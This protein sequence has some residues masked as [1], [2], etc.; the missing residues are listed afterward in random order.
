MPTSSSRK[1]AEEVSTTMKTIPNFWEILRQISVLF[2]T[3]KDQPT[4]YES[5]PFCA[6]GRQM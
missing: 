2:L 1:G 5:R 4:V 3:T 6:E